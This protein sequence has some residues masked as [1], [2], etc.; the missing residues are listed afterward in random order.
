MLE[1][2][3]IIP[4]KNEDD[5]V[6]ALIN[7]I[8]NQTFQPAMVILVDGGSTDDTISL[9]KKL[10]SDDK[11]YKLIE[12]GNAMPGKGRN[13]GAEQAD[14]EWI[15]FTDAGI[16]LDNRWLENLTQKAISNTDTDIVYGNYSPYIQTFFE[17]CATFC[18]V[19]PLRNGNIRAKS[20]VSCLLK[21]QVWKDVGGFPD[22]RAAEDLN[23]IEKVEAKKFKTVF[24]PKAFVYWSLQPGFKST[25]KKFELYSMHNVWN[26]LQSRWH[27]GIL[28]QYLVML[29]FVAVG[30]FYTPIGFL[31]IPSWLIARAIKRI[32]S[33]RQ[34]FGDI[35]II[36]PRVILMVILITVVIDIAT[37]SGWIRAIITQRENSKI[38][39]WV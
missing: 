15:A 4:L 28:K 3:L 12:T 34:E 2:S 31:A 20:I 11:K 21:R 9:I 14:T 7:S 22:W 8:K 6:E 35:N 32:F 39:L 1:I 27:Y 5:T 36:K 37:F 24:E 13:I 16:N 19:P 17:K 29:F 30:I 23:F 33:H 18:Y 10:V 38:S 26:G 25:Y